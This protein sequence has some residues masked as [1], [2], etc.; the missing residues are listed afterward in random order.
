MKKKIM[1]SLQSIIVVFI[2]ISTMSSVVLAAPG[3][4]STGGLG[5][6][7]YDSCPY[8]PLF[9]VNYLD[10]LTGRM[11]IWVT[12]SYRYINNDAYRSRFLYASLVDM[13]IYSGHGDIS[14]ERSTAHFNVP[15]HSTHSSTTVGS[16]QAPNTS[17]NFHHPYVVMYTCNWLNFNNVTREVRAWET[18]ESGCRITCGFGNVM[19]LDSAEGNMFGYRMVD[20]IET[21]KTAFF[22]SAMYYQPQNSD[23]VIARV[24]THIP[25]A[26]DT[27]YSG[28]TGAVPGYSNAT[29]SSYGSFMITIP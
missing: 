4:N 23:S 28:Y 9:G 16:F 18:F 14:D 12:R 7:N 8:L 3:V 26:N 13:F 10:K 22:N 6:N 27:F 1:K 2:L 20:Y 17:T 19:F 25:S 15:S 11:P 24:A 29:A 21:I 5:V